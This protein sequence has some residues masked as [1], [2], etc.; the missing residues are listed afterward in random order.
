M[1]LSV[2]KANH[3]CKYETGYIGGDIT[4]E[5][6]HA[7]LFNEIEMWKEKEDLQQVDVV[8]ATPP[9]QGMSTAGKLDENDIRNVLFQ[10]AVD[11]ILDLSQNTLCLRLYLLL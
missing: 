7:K 2:Q 3:K 6:T 10:H 5:E 1:R 8:F 4:S 9:C 11:S